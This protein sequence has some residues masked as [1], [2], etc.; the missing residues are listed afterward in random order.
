MAKRINKR[1]RRKKAVSPTLSILLMIIV[2]IAAS[3]IVYMWVM[4][5]FSFTSTKS[6]KSIQIQSA[7]LV[8][9]DIRHLDLKTF[10]QNVGQGSVN[11]DSQNCI[12]VNNLLK[13]AG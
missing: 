12:Y 1:V 2:A 6:G 4:G 13:N 11:F 10:V 7:A 8:G 9:P 5:Y 3:L